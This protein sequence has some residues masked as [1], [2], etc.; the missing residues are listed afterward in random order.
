[1]SETNK[2]NLPKGNSNDGRFT[3]MALITKNNDDHN[4]NNI[5]NSKISCTVDTHTYTLKH[6]HTS[7]MNNAKANAIV[8]CNT[9]RDDQQK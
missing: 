8:K 2:D 9:K 3:L 5:I 1:M 6:T 4:N 7:E